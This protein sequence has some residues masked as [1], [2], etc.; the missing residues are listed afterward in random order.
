MLADPLLPAAVNPLA[1]SC[2][3]EPGDDGPSGV[4]RPPAAPSSP[5]SPGSPSSPPRSSFS[6]PAPSP[7]VAGLRPY[8]RTLQGAAID[9]RLDGNEGIAPPADLLEALRAEGPGILA[10]Y[11]D[12]TRL[13]AAWAERFGVEPARVLAT[14]GADEALERTLRAFL[15]PGRDLLLPV[16]TFEMLPRYAALAGGEVVPVDWP[17]GAF[18]VDAVLARCTPRTAV[19]AV[20]S[21]NNP[22]GAVAT[23]RDLQRL[24]GAVPGAVLLV[25]LAYGEFADVDLTAE[26]LALPNAIVARTLSKA[27]GLAGVRAGCA[28]GAAALIEELRAAGS[29]YSVSGPAVALATAWLARGGP[30]VAA[31]VER[32][33]VE[34]RDLA[35]MLGAAGLDVASSQGN[36]VFARCGG[37]A[38]AEALVTGLAARG[39]A[40]RGFAGR[41][42]LADAVRISCPAD[43]AAFARLQQALAEV[44]AE[45]GR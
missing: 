38:R 15:G 26:A 8:R 33:R 28:V 20:V 39:I 13:E 43:A 9:L 37:A 11:P 10:C 45:I 16:P 27:W 30:A 4:D 23:A 42:G 44:L 6:S 12:A 34:R 41:A 5:L 1:S 40:V 19:I 29:P 25:D 7:R 2:F 17:G 18:P 22:T 24:S 14:A 21:P 32:V 36:F 35:G 31:V 3:L